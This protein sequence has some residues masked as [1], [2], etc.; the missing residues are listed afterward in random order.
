VAAAAQTCQA[1]VSGNTLDSSVLEFTPTRPA[2]GGLNLSCDCFTAGSTVLV[3]QTLLPILCS[4]Q[5]ESRAAILGGTENAFAPTSFYFQNVFLP[6][7]RRM[8]INCTS[9]CGP[10]GW[11]PKGKGELRISVTPSW[12]FTPLHMGERG[13]LLAV[14]GACIVSNLNPQI[15]QRMK[16]RLLKNLSE[17][18][19]RGKPKIQEVVAPSVGIGAEAF[20]SCV[21]EDGRAGF[22]SLGEL[23]KPSEKVAGEAAHGL[24]EFHKMSANVDSHLADQ[25]LVYCALAK[26][27]SKFLAPAITDHMQTNAKT[28]TDFL[29]DCA[30]LFEQTPSGTKVVVKPAGV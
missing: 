25:L 9:R 3:A 10:F 22:T 17:G 1:K 13:R 11:F 23:A 15:A 24:L 19:V 18:Q 27:T 4:G 14:E 26:G 6:A 20:V 7:I 8:G 2:T 16:A 30:I 29:P 5:Q 21:Y 28:I 12:P